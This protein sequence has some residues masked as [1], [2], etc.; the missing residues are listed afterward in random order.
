MAT[1]TETHQIKIETVIEDAN[2]KALI[3]SI[4]Q[5]QSKIAGLTAR[6][7]DE[8]KAAKTAGIASKDL[9]DY[10]KQAGV[11][12][13]VIST[14][15]TDSNNALR[16]WATGLNKAQVEIDVLPQ[17]IAIVT[18]KLDA[19]NAE[20][21]QGT[22]QFGMLSNELKALQAVSS[23]AAS[24][25]A[26]HDSAQRQLRAG[27]VNT[28]YQLQDIAVQ[29]QAGTKL[30]VIALQQI[31]QLVSGF[32]V[33]AKAVLVAVAALAALGATIGAPWLNAWLKA[34][35]AAEDYKTGL[36]GIK[37]G[38]SELQKATSSFS[39]DNLR[40]QFNAADADSRVLLV[41]LTK[42]REATLRADLVKLNEGWKGQIE[43]M[44]GYF[45]SFW[46]MM[47]TAPQRITSA[48][49]LT[50][51][52]TSQVSAVILAL[53]NDAIT[54]REALDLLSKH[55]GEDASDE[56]LKFV[57]TLAE[58]LTKQE[59]VKNAQKELKTFYAEAAKAGEKGTIVIKAEVAERKAATKALK[60]HNAALQEYLGLTQSVKTP[61][62][63]YADTI[64]KLDELQEKL[65]GTAGVSM[66]MFDRM[67]QNAEALRETANNE[68]QYKALSGMAKGYEDAD[69]Q[70]KAAR[71]SAEEL[72]G[73][74]ARLSELRMQGLT[75]DADTLARKLGEA[76]PP[77]ERIALAIESVTNATTG[78]EALEEQFARMTSGLSL[79]EAELKK[80]R[81]TVGLPIEKTMFDQIG[82]AVGPLLANGVSSFVDTLL[83]SKKSFKDWAAS[84]IGEIGKVILKLAVVQAMKIAL[85][86][87]GVGAFLFGS[88]KGNIFGGGLPLKPGIYDKPTFFPLAG[89]TLTKFATGGV[90]NT[91]VLAEAGSPEAVV[92]LQRTDGILGVKASPVNIQIINNAGAAVSATTA[93]NSDGSKEIKIMIDRQ[94]KQ[95]MIDG[96]YDQIMRSAFGLRRASYSV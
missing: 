22:A 49:K 59:E 37:T 77:A 94:V 11:S 29:L 90:I 9:A 54:S 14:S 55:V 79:T 8:M 67:R 66:D 24:S 50:K 21:K 25:V 26:K 41:T 86:G 53:K 5:A 71:V 44:T 45:S 27:L 30:Q 19:L 2:L 65:K 17:K 61:D 62:E 74:L 76:A 13:D 93:D 38:L 58:Y 40:K 31:P 7:T 43:G 51:E 64:A 1:Q 35:K 78:I 36:E 4:Q 32:G 92:P 23:G 57:N 81:E 47:Q 89:G 20:G 34:R 6:L 46:S 96:T 56:Y 68:E 10:L 12:A 48:L 42:V 83:D 85:A 69:R 16:Q 3:S 91:G 72:D 70:I 80:V 84:L 82:E 18:A 95:G 73:Q 60:E 88:A 63:I 39:L 52:Q 87:T 28:S 75:E 33:Y 15:L